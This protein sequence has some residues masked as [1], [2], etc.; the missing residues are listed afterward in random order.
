MK[1]TQVLI[2]AVLIA[3]LTMTGCK[4]EGC[5]DPVATNYDSQAKEDDGSCIFPEPDPDARDP[6]LG[7]YFVTDSMWLGGNFY[8]VKIYTLQVTTGGTKK[9]TIYLNNLWNG[10]TNYIALMAGSN[11]SI[12]SQQV[13]GPYYASGNGSFNNNVITYQTS[14]DVYQNK[15]TGTKQ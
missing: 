5:T 1:K 10:G 8:E 6:Y 4:K 2:A 9:D 12:P 3:M 11:F 7:N 15:G 13:S 14:G